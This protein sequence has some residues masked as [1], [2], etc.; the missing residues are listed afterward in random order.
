M[1]TK[2]IVNFQN[3]QTYKLLQKKSEVCE[4]FFLQKFPLYV[5]R[6][7]AYLMQES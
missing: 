2:A 4:N 6:K 7:D 3:K 1:A 5:N